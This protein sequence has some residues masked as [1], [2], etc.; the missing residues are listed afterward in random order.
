M[1][2]TL[3]R[4]WMPKDKDDYPRVISI[5]DFTNVLSEFAK[6][7]EHQRNRFVFRGVP[8]ASHGL[9]PS[10][11]RLKNCWRDR[12]LLCHIENEAT[13]YFA[14]R[15]HLHI[16]ARCLPRNPKGADDLLLYWQYMQHHGA[17]T[18]L[19]DWTASPYAAAYF[20]VAGQ[21]E[22]DGAVWMVDYGAHMDRMRERHASQYDP[23][24]RRNFPIIGSDGNHHE[25]QTSLMFKPCELVNERMSAQRGWFSCASLLDEDHGEAIARAF[26]ARPGEWSLKV[27]IPSEAKSGFLR[28]LWR[29]NISGETLFPGL[30]GLGRAMSEFG[31]LLKPDKAAAYSLEFGLLATSWLPSTRNGEGR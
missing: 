13:N 23:Q 7:R 1:D 9:L 31:D 4:V 11:S 14:A 6:P 16:E 18:R 25:L 22:S 19:L 21:P 10:L 29:M 17:K 28:E 24:G 5:A 8:Q 2:E 20:A 15:A 3:S 12:A 26:S 30:D 27:I